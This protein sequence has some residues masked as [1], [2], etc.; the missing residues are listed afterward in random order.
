[1][2]KEQKFHRAFKLQGKSF[3]SVEELLNFSKDLSVTVFNF[4]EKW[5][6]KNDVVKVQTSGSTGKPKSILLKKQYMVNSALATGEFFNLSENT[7]ALLCLSVNY[8]AGKMMLVRALT[9]GWNLDFIEPISNPLKNNIKKYDFLAMVPLQLENSLDNL[10][11]VKKIIVG[12][13]PVSN[14]LLKQL[15]NIDTTVFATYGMTE[16]ITHIAVKRLNNFKTVI[17]S[18]TKQ[19]LYQALPNIKISKD[20]RNCLVINAPNIS[21]TKIVTNDI[22]EIISSTEFKWIGRLDTIINSGGVKLFPEE[23]ES[24]LSKCIKNEFFVAGIKDEKLGEKLIL[25]IENSNQ[26]STK[27]FIF[28][29][30]NSLKT[31]DKYQKPKEIFFVDKLVKTPTEK[32][33]RKETLKKIVTFP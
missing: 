11:N 19:S 22:V 6:D 33:N 20:D 23:I 16:T 3:K 32:I 24:K 12:G 10:S 21:D 4:L 8:I 2:N 14:H 25:V 28:N 27:E 5:F 30:I 9:L 26:N 7:N 17:A 13:A 1:M 31:L 29:Q 15:Q 18:E